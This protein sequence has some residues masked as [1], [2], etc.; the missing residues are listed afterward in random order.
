MKISEDSFDYVPG[1]V[2]D[3]VVKTWN[4]KLISDVNLFSFSEIDTNALIDVA[5]IEFNSNIVNVDLNFGRDALG[6]FNFN[7]NFGENFTLLNSSFDQNLD[8]SGLMLQNVDAAGNTAYFGGISMSET[9]FS[10]GDNIIS[11]SLEY[12]GEGEAKIDFT[13]VFLEDIYSG[14]KYGRSSFFSWC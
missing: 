2:T 9:L 11:L 3:T 10:K 1:I 14:T 7:L 5:N 4:G 6:V 8:Q 13:D 12:K